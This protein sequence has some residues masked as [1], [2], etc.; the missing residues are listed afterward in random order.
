MLE[1]GGR[2]GRQAED[3]CAGLCWKV[4][5]VN[6]LAVCDLQ[7]NVALCIASRRCQLILMYGKMIG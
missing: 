4:A 6:E 5:S 1:G 7:V 2:V 3:G